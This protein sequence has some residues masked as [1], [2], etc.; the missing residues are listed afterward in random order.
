MFFVIAL[1]NHNFTQ[2]AKID[3]PK[4]RQPQQLLGNPA[5]PFFNSPVTP[6]D[7]NAK[8]VSFVSLAHAVHAGRHAGD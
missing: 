4:K 5:C 3:N 2:P 7:P 6:G 8:Y 1:E